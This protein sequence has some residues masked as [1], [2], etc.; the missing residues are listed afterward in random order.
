MET[1]FDIGACCN[2]KITGHRSKMSHE[3][4]F[5]VGMIYIFLVAVL[6]GAT[7]QF[8]I[9]HKVISCL[10]PVVVYVSFSTFYEF[11]IPR[12]GGGASLWPIDI[13]FVA[14]VTAVGGA[15]G[16]LLTIVY[17]RLRN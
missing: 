17:L 8:F 6:V 9:R 13:L 5:G 3:H 4:G 14:P 15:V 16:A 11:L 7:A 1:S 12:H 2:K 10:A